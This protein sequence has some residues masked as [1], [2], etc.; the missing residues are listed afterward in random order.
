MKS[1]SM[2]EQ[3][4][5]K[6]V[7]EYLILRDTA[8]FAG[9]KDTEKL[10]W[11]EHLIYCDYNEMT[12]HCFW[13]YLEG[14]GTHDRI[15]MLERYK[16]LI[17]EGKADCIRFIDLIS[18]SE[19][20]ELI[21][22]CSQNNLSVNERTYLVHVFCK[23]LKNIDDNCS[24]DISI[25][26]Q[27]YFL[28]LLLDVA[29]QHGSII[30]E[31]ST[32]YQYFIPRLIINQET[33][34]AAT[35]VFSKLIE[36]W[37]DSA[38]PQQKKFIESMMDLVKARFSNIRNRYEKEKS[39]IIEDFFNFSLGDYLTSH[40]AQFEEFK[41]LFPHLNS[42]F[43]EPLN[44]FS[45]SKSLL[46]RFFCEPIFFRKIFIFVHL[47]DQTENRLI[48]FEKL[49]FLESFFEYL[50]I[51]SDCSNFLKKVIQFVN[52]MSSK[53]LK[54]IWG[55]AFGLYGEINTLRKVWELQTLSNCG[56][57]VEIPLEID[58]KKREKI[59]DVRLCF[60]NTK[61]YKCFE[62]KCKNHGF[63]FDGDESELNDYLMNLIPLI[64]GYV[65]ICIPNISMLQLFPKLVISNEYTFGCL[66][67]LI[68]G[69]SEKGIRVNYSGNELSN[70]NTEKEVLKNVLECFYDNEFK[71][72]GAYLLPTDAEILNNKK[73]L[74]NILF[75][76][77]FLRNTSVAALRKFQDENKKARDNSISID[78]FVFCWTLFTPDCLVYS[79]FFTQDSF[80][81]D[82][83]NHIR[84]G[85]HEIF[86]DVLLSPE[87][88]DLQ[89][90]KVE[91]MFL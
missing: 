2:K 65:N 18:F 15:W 78:S 12:N 91:L 84:N 24:F 62:S 77:D 74:A 61:S 54:N 51:R 8:K 49:Q 63:G 75:A 11:Y 81:V 19:L 32:V 4:T 66:S 73:Q 50:S 88:S 79:P 59:G 76:K 64:S 43:V 86:N 48:Y 89:N 29:N 72:T 46:Y 44:E 71:M 30:Y 47:P 80:T 69:M 21:A 58:G 42:L 57:H 70:V 37:R 6:F 26:A 33:E 45:F 7:D 22:V 34:S 23:L 5:D 20:D 83:V 13:G 41:T 25:G 17:K 52:L 82:L 28:N 16:E 67:D 9:I 31:S 68:H 14:V 39:Q 1:Q 35:N 3:I 60:P 56:S 87:F 90:Q 10:F 55:A 27:I 85:V 36:Y 53:S 40:K 38:Y